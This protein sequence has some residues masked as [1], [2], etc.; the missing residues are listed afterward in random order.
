MFG[1]ILNYQIKDNQVIIN[2]ENQKGIVEVLT[3]EIIN[4]HQEKTSIFKATGE[5]FSKDTKFEVK[6][7]E[8]KIVITTSS[9]TFEILDDFKLNVIQDGVLISSEKDVIIN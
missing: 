1:K 3:S 2:F 5:L 7:E 6:Q 4:L 8:N 9:Y